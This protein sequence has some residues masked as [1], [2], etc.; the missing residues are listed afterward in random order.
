LLENSSGQNHFENLGVG[1]DNIKLEL[2]V[3]LWKYRIDLAQD[4][5]DMRVL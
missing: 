1:E 5:G 3:I 4:K 2:K